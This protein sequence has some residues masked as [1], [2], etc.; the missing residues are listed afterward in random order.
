MLQLAHAV[1]TL[2]NNGVVMKPHLV[3]I[4][5]DGATRARTLTVPKESR[6]IPLKQE[7]IDVIK[8][9]HGRRDAEPSGT[10]RLRVRQR[11]LHLGRQDRH[12]AGG[13]PEGG[14]KYNAKPIGERLRDNALYV[15]FAPADK[16][17]IA[18]ALVVENAGFG[19]AVRRADRAQGARLLPARQAPGGR[20]TAPSPVE[21]AVEDCRPAPAPFQPGAEP[22]RRT[23]RCASTNAVRCGA[24]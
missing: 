14:E 22:P 7:N 12:R 18:L 19:A 13:R 3:K 1:S 15:A 2:A 11:R 8:R 23:D 17:R 24:A 9:A 16:P 20:R 4:I 6:R 21:V 10:G 5:E